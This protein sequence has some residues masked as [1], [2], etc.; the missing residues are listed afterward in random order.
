VVFEDQEIGNFY[1]QTI[2]D[3]ILHYE[4]PNTADFVTK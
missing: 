3:Q 1:D 4:Q 2:A